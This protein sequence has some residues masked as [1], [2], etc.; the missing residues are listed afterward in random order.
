[1]ESVL[2]AIAILLAG[3]AGPRERNAIFKAVCTEIL[4]GR[5]R[6]GDVISVRAGKEDCSLSIKN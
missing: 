6:S 4:A 5:V 3:P 2:Q 1:V